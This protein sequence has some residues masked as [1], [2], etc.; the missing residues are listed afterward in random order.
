M[1]F[2]SGVA[3]ITLPDSPD[4]AWIHGGKKGLIIAADTALVS[5]EGHFTDYPG[6]QE[7]AAI[8]IPTFG[9]IEP[10]HIVLHPGACKA[11]EI[12]L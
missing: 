2:V 5:K 9:G 10:D 12:E 1:A 4:E 6:S 3:H 8:L 11:S 7:T